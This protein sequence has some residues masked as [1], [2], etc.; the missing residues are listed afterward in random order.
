MSFVWGWCF[1]LVSG[2]FFF[3]STKHIESFTFHLFFRNLRIV[4]RLQTFRWPC[5]HGM[6]YKKR[7]V[8]LLAAYRL[9]F[10]GLSFRFSC[11][12]HDMLWKWIQNGNVSRSTAVWIFECELHLLKSLTTS[13]LGLFSVTLAMKNISFS[14]TS[15]LANQVTTCCYQTNLSAKNFPHIE[16]RS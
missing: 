14:V 13:Q 4:N 11:S 9:S 5:A 8:F 10:V 16:W 12:R 1:L 6:S 7:T 2:F 15:R 3:F